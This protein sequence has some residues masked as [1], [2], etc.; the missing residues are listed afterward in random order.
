MKAE[1]HSS[2]AQKLQT[3]EL[4]KV[5]LI[6]NPNSGKS[7]LFN[8]LTGMHQKTGNF[9]GVTVDK[10]TGFCKADNPFT[11]KTQNFEIVDLPGTYSLYPKS[12]DEKVAFD[13]LLKEENPDYPDLIIIVVDSSNLKRNLLLATQIIDLGR[14]TVVALNMI[15]VALHS[16]IDIDIE[17]LRNWLGVPVVALNSRNKEGIDELKKACFKTSK[18][19]QSHLTLSNVINENYLNSVHAHVKDITPYASLIRQV[20]HS[21][22][23]TSS[24][25]FNDNIFK[26]IEQNETIARFDYINKSLG[27]FQKNSESKKDLTFTQKLDKWLT[28]PI[29]GF[30]FFLSILFL[31]FQT[32]FYLAEFPMTWIETGFVA[33]GSLVSESLSPGPLNDL[34]VNGIIAGLSGVAVFIPQIALLFGF[35]SVLEDSGY[36]A[37]VSYIMDKLMRRFGLNGRSVIPLIS[38]IACAVPAVMGT[39]TIANYKER[40]ITIMVTPLMSC[41]ARL[42][43]YTLLIS[44]MV[45]DESNSFFNTRGLMLMVL[46]LLGF[47]AA[48]LAALLFKFILKAR[49]RS[50]FIMEL[51]VYRLPQLK[52]VFLTMFDKVK[53]FLW[54]AGKV[55]V[56]VSIILWAL[57][58][59]GPGDAMAKI[60]TKYNDTT[61][62]A[63]KNLSS[64]EKEILKNSEKLSASYAGSIGKFIEPAI[65][66]LGFDWKIGIS[67]ITSFAAREVFV[68]T[69]ATLY[70]AGDEENTT[71]IREK[72][73]NEINP[74]TQ[75][76]FYTSAVCWSLLLFYAFAMQCIST[77]A[78]VYRETKGWKWPLIQIAYMSALAYLTSFIVYQLMS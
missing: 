48:L 25:L 5:A 56:A 46:Y 53:V 50:Y 14:P 6:G 26:N 41:S 34:L 76:P 77:I 22:E 35:I 23:S 52:T 12:I 68:G 64:E 70:S 49:E 54:D 36:M 18:V 51:P 43:V 59:Y 61:N 78:V 66:P 39:R 57:S 75:K 67:L 13:V 20:E 27:A 69:M 74:S 8:A 11:K 17:T 9:A 65:R 2:L 42:P 38:G 16:G 73:Q 29:L 15:D 62:I 4:V 33:L 7:T 44:L 28:H 72:M 24:K 19:S 31:V 37:R 63:I 58:S 45:K 3:G 30:V 21:D 47:I 71:S 60:E 10:K 1:P 32:I 55:I 40:L